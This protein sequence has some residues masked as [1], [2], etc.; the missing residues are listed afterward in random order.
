MAVIHLSLENFDSEVMESSVPVLVD[1]WATWC[2]PCRMLAP[3]IEELSEEL[4]DVKV[5]KV[6]VDEEEELSARY[7][8]MSIPTLLVFKDGKLAK[9][10]VGFQSK[11][12][13]I[14]LI[15]NA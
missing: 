6:D 1:F 5:C 4:T 9:Q 15:K 13:L 7:G 2:A 3:I 12:K 8:V 14:D 11:E 10:T